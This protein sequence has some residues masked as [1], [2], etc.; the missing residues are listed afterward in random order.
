LASQWRLPVRAG[1][2]WITEIPAKKASIEITRRSKNLANKAVVLYQS[3]KIKNKWTMRRAEGTLRNLPEGSY[4]VSYYDGTRKRMEPVGRD[5]KEAL[6]SIKKKQLELLYVAEGGQIAMPLNGVLFQQT[7]L[8]PPRVKKSFA[9]AI[10][11]YLDCVDRQGKSGYGLAP[12]TVRHTAI[13][14]LSSSSSIPVPS[15]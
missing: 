11:E 7:D 15:G 1:T 12:R 4:Y 10:K 8:H 3:I 13:V 9:A 6:N 2:R 5:P 14:F